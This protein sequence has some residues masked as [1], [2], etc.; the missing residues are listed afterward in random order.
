[1]WDTCKGSRSIT[2]NDDLSFELHN[3]S[4]Q[5][6]ETDIVIRSADEG[7]DCIILNFM[8]GYAQ[9]ETNYFLRVDQVLFKH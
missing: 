2:F 5:V 7:R 4:S 6:D 8:S 3:I 1:M 9:S